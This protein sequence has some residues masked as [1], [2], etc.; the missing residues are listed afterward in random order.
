M[1]GQQQGEGE[2]VREDRMDGCYIHTWV[3]VVHGQQRM[4]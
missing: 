1:A 3:N 4:N 2:E